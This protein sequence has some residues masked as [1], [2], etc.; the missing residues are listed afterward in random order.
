MLIPKV[1]NL[2]KVTQYRPISLCI[3]VSRL[4]SKVLTNRLKHLFPHI[5]SENQSAFM[6]NRLFTNNMLVAFEA[7]HHISQKRSGK[8][9]EMALKLD[10]SKAYNRKEWGCLENIMLKTGFNEKW[11]NVMIRC[12]N[13]VSYFVLINGVLVATLS[14]LGGLREGTHYSHTCFCC[15]QRVYWCCSKFNRPMTFEGSSNLPRW[16]KDIPPTFCK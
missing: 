3:V 10:M 5:I 8:V 14:Q 6:S 4:A 11:V 2:T 15:M 1:K 9:G 7:M 13:T 16:T 12:V